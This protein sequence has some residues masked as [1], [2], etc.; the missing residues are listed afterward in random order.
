MRVA[1]PD[2][3]VRRRKIKFRHRGNNVVCERCSE[4]DGREVTF[5]SNTLAKTGQPPL[6]CP[7][8]KRYDFWKRRGVEGG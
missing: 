2:S 3:E 8:C 1:N 7:L 4:R 6:Q 5:F